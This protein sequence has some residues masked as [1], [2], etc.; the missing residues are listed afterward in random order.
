[1][2]KLEV[3]TV[4]ELRAEG[5]GDEM[6][7]VGYAALFN[8]R[9]RNLGGFVEQ[10]APG[11]FT[12]SLA[13]NADVKVTFNHDP[14]QVLGR[15][16]SKTA[17]VEQDERGLKF[18]CQL[19]PTNTMH[20]NI[21]ASVKRGDIDECSFAFRVS[22]EGQEWKAEEQNGNEDFLAV[23][24]LKDVDLVD[25]SAVT[26]PAYFGTSV[27]ARALFPEGDT[28]VR[29]TANG[30]LAAA[31]RARTDSL[32]AQASALWEAMSDALRQ[33]FGLMEN[34]Y[35]RKYWGPVETY[36]DHIIACSYGDNYEAKYF[37]IPYTTKDGGYVYGEPK[38][39]E[40]DWV[41]SERGMKMQAE[42]RSMAEKAKQ[43][44]DIAAAHTDA[45]AAHTSE[46]TE[47]K[48]AAAAISA[49]AKQYREDNGLLDDEDYEDNV[50]CD[51][52]MCWEMDPDDDQSGD[53]DPDDMRSAKLARRT[54]RRAHIEV[55]DDGKVRT[56]KVAGKNLTADKFAFVGDKNDTSTWKFPV[57]DE[58]HARNALARWSQATGIPEEK[59]AAAYRKI[60]SA[61]KKFGIEVSDDASRS[62]I[63]TLSM[64]ADEIKDRLLRLRALVLQP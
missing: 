54:A 16:K 32:E 38:P 42:I 15:T 26:Y 57:H 18:R 7:L 49:A 39:V 46:A 29:G 51:R 13:E 9:S 20:R 56:K 44:E 36:T 35:D 22:T 61:A 17:T 41:A 12:R 25:V 33:Q 6:A 53:A 8:A 58:A 3:R 30:V 40:L 55:R 60:V 52:D 2:K 21:H 19:D 63:A 48:A 45:A 23:R 5:Q 11:A 64:D 59:K 47:H 10:I 24:T 62:V 27:D 4:T 34:G 14:N 37:S 31:K 50:M 28:E 43:H 1:M